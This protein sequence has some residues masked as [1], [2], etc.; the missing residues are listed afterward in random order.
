MEKRDSKIMR[1]T[2]RTPDDDDTENGSDSDSL[3][4]RQLTAIL[5]AQQILRITTLRKAWKEHT[6]AGKKIGQ[7][8]PSKVI[9]LSV[10][11]YT[12]QQLQE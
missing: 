5:K 11:L 8:V 1:N 12:R 7:T 9:A 4:M 10:V 3:S 6:T 2:I